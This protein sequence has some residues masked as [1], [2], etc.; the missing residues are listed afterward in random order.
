MTTIAIPKQGR[1]CK[2]CG[3][4]LKSGQEKFCSNS[5]AARFRY[6]S[7]QEREAHRQN[8]KRLNT[9]LEPSPS[10]EGF[11][12]AGIYTYIYAL[13]DPRYHCIRYVG[14]SRKPKRRFSAHLYKAGYSLRQV[15][16]NHLLYDW[17]GEL[18]EINME[19]TMVCFQKVPS[20]MAWETEQNWIEYGLECGW[21]LFNR[22]GK[23]KR[24]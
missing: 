3:K 17:I 4:R 21:P 8:Q 2:W 12:Y 18:I 22:I 16:E 1:Q 24:Q 6:A 15:G 10:Q 14:Q 20:R 13:I 19:P 9:K 23:G 5:H 7:P 11:N